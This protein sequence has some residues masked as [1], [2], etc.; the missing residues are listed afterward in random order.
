MKLMWNESIRDQM[1]K[2]KDTDNEYYR[3]V[4]GKINIC[5]QKR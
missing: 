2:W 5:R 3:T 1:K 4:L